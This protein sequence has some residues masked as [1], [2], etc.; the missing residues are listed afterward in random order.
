MSRI[1]KMTEE[2]NTNSV[3]SKEIGDAC[4]TSSIEDLYISN[5]FTNCITVPSGNFSNSSGGYIISG[6]TGAGSISN[7]S[8]SNISFPTMK[9]DIKSLSGE[10]APEGAILTV[11]KHGEVVWS[12]S[13][14]NIE[15]IISNPGL[16]AAFE[17]LIQAYQE[18]KMMERLSNNN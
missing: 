13:L 12:N 5:S 4:Y 3:I 10:N 15:T 17:K 6:G 9:I 2:A 11:D 8:L 18:F 7:I 14:P 16:S 1:F